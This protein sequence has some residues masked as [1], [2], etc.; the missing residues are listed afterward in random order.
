[1][2]NRLLRVSKSVRSERDGTDAATNSG[3]I[4]VFSVA[5][6]LPYQNTEFA[7]KFPRKLIKKAACQPNSPPRPGCHFRAQPTAR[8]VVTRDDDS[9]LHAVGV[10]ST[11]ALGNSRQSRKPPRKIDRRQHKSRRCDARNLPPDC[12]P[13]NGSLD[14]AGNFPHFL[15]TPSST[16]GSGDVLTLPW[17]E[18]VRGGVDTYRLRHFECHFVPRSN[19]RRY[20]TPRR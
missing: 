4:E 19:A 12:S 9:N 17:R 7:T 13:F 18:S 11:K 1:M 5:D 2:T 6:P 8:Q 15:E 16:R 20:R 3:G 14:R 10:E